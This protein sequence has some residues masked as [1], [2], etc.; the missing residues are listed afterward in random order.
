VRI[1][2]I[3]LGNFAR[4][5]QAWYT[6]AADPDREWGIAAFTG[7]GP[8]AAEALAPQQGLYTLIERGPVED[9]LSIVDVLQDARPGTDVGALIAAV[10]AP[11]T[12]VVTLTVTEAGYA[13]TGAESVPG[14]LA[15]ALGQRRMSGS[16][17]LAVVSCDNLHA[18]GELLRARTLAAADNPLGEW[19]EREVSF[20]ST[21]VDRITPRVTAE[22]R[23]LAEREL[24]LIDAA[25]VVTE[26]FTDW[27]LCGEFPAGRPEWERAGARFVTDIEPW[28]LRKLWLLNGG[29]S[30][31]AYLGLVRGHATVADAVADRELVAA[32]HEFWDLAGRYLP[33]GVDLDLPAYR[34]QLLERFENA[35]I[36]YPLL[37]IADD[38]FDKLRVRV[39]PVI[40]AAAAAG[41]PAAPAMRIVE[42]WAR[43][44]S[45]DPERAQT[46]Q[47]ARV[48]RRVLGS[49]GGDDT[50]RGLI[51]LLEIE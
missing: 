27:V 22:D 31:L 36:G 9:Q 44:L 49:R 32:L 29:H 40:E 51:E 25:P 6:M 13:G 10:A 48:L 11:G 39:V 26:P 1:V 21:S 46:D 2:H 12:C 17:P 45:A 41:M 34:A 43:W 23:A 38:G 7:R 42:A 14:R 4:A 37:Q 15:L 5:H 20:V 28:E 30:L 3:G 33:T 47:N 24:G 19:I 50:I 18:N 35:R 16:G 8:G